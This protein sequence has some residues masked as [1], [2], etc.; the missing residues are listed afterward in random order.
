MRL[1]VQWTSFSACLYGDGWR[2][3]YVLAVL[4]DGFRNAQD[5][6]G[7]ADTM[8]QHVRLP[9][10]RSGERAARNIRPRVFDSRRRS[11]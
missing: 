3:L 1:A 5:V 4:A 10:G 11:R 7:D 2:R 6:R 9:G 8:A